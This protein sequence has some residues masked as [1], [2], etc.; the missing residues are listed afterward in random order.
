MNTKEELIKAVEDL[1]QDMV[2]MKSAV[3]KL[4]ELVEKYMPK[5]DKDWFDE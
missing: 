1:Q 5:K 4:I 2:K 3:K